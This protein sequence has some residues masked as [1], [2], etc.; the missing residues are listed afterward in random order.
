[1]SG[2]NIDLFGHADAHARAMQNWASLL[3]TRDGRG[4]NQ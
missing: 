2:G 1:M 3:G 4:G